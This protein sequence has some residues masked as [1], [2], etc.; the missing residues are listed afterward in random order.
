VTRTYTHSSVEWESLRVLSRSDFASRKHTQDASP[1]DVLARRSERDSLREGRVTSLFWSW[2]TPWKRHFYTPK[3]HFPASRHLQT[4]LEVT[5]VR[6]RPNHLSSAIPVHTQ[7]HVLARLSSRHSE[8]VTRHLT[9]LVSTLARVELVITTSTPLWPDLGLVTQPSLQ[10]ISKPNHHSYT[11]RRD[12][13]LRSSQVPLGHTYT[14]ARRPV[15][16]WTHVW[17]C[18]QTCPVL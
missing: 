12:K 4:S 6:T 8:S 11:V 13:P 15:S 1:V 5:S 17:T 14:C 7:S 3:R 9:R 18:V 10:P 2:L 16:S